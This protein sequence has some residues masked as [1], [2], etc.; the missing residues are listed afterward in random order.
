MIHQRRKRENLYSTAAYWDSKAA[1]YDNTAVSM[2]PNQALNQLYEI[3]LQ[4]LLGRYLSDLTGLHILDLGCGTGRFSRW[5]ARQGARVTGIDFSSRALAIAQKQSMGN[6]PQYRHGS[7]FELA[8]EQGYD[9][10]F[11]WGVLTLACRDQ[12]ELYDVLTRIGRALRPNGRLLLTEP[13]HQGFL[14][15]VL[16]L[17]LANFLAVMRAAG[18]QVQT[19]APLHFWPTRLVLAYVPWPMWITAPLYYLGQ[20]AMKLP[21]LASLGDY[22]AILARPVDAARRPC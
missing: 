11:T 5:F 8:E 1:A 10:I 18:F 7:V 13:I 17:N 21:G 9:L 19:K 22:H 3:E 14:H 20:A 2:W 6:N 12:D 4:R 16:N 15:R